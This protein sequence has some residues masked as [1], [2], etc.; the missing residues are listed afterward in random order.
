V[1]P[2]KLYGGFEIGGV[3]EYISL[4]KYNGWKTIARKRTRLP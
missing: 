2:L 4:N 1:T 3:P